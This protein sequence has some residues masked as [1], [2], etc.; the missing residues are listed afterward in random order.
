MNTKLSNYYA[1]TFDKAII[2]LT[3]KNKVNI[4]SVQVNIS[5]ENEPTII[6]LFTKSRNYDEIFDFFLFHM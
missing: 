3:V 6:I 1:I 5:M 4:K 2:Y